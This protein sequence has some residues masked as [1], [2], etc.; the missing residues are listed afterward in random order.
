MGQSATV[1]IA[2]DS[3]DLR[4]LMVFQLENLGYQTAEAA[5]GLEAIEVARKT[6]PSLIL[7]DINMPLLDG[8]AATRVIRESP[9]ISATP[10][11][12]FSAYFGAANRERALAAGCDDYLNKTECVDHLQNILQRFVPLEKG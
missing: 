1:L 9:Q 2:D 11:V 7:M 12:A 4:E 6:T 8:L 10:I 3:D 5:N